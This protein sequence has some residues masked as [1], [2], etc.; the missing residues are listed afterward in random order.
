MIIENNNFFHAPTG[1]TLSSPFRIRLGGESSFIIGPYNTF[2]KGNISI[3]TSATG[4]LKNEI[5]CNSFESF[6]SSG[7]K[8]EH[9]NGALQILRNTFANPTGVEINVTGSINPLQGNSQIS[10][11]NC[12]DNPVNAILASQNNT[13]EFQYFVFDLDDSPQFCEK[14]TNNLS[15]GGTNNYKLRNS[16]GKFEDCENGTPLPA[17]T[18]SDLTNIRQMTTALRDI[19][20]NDPQNLQKLEQYQHSAAMQDIILRALARQAL[21]LN[22]YN[23]AEYLLLGENTNLWRRAVVGL[24]TQRGNIASAQSLLNSMPIENQDD[25]WFKDIMAINF[26]IEQSPNPIAYQ[27]S[28]Q[29]EILLQTI[30]NTPASI[31]KGYAC[32]LLSFCKGYTCDEA[33]GNDGLSSTHEIYDPNLVQISPNPTSGEIK[34]VCPGYIDELINL[35]F[36]DITGRLVVSQKVINTGS[37]NYYSDALENGLYILRLSNK[38]KVIY[39]DKVIV[40]R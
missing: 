5:K 4:S 35:D 40:I 21:E 30:A 12:F 7:I 20:L 18:E 17:Y 13:T 29:Q 33:A 27:L 23:Y 37:F 34:V 19:W 1:L 36:F 6:T 16:I 39:T 10:S 25:I 3:L 28:S 31:M 11:A 26:Q 2:D 8:S 32:A 38:N 24:R 9:N 15:D 14:P 22:D